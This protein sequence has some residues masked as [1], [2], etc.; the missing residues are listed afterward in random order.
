MLKEDIS[1]EMGQ[2]DELVEKINFME[3][4]NEMEEENTFLLA[5]RAEKQENSVLTLEQGE[6]KHITEGMLKGNC[7]KICPPDG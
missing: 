1:E 5:G 4:Q 2:H 7:M 3:Y 6:E